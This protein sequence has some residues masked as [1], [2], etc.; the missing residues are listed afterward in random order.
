MLLSNYQKTEIVIGTIMFPYLYY[1]YL[2]VTKSPVII[3]DILWC[4]LTLFIILLFKNFYVNFN[5]LQAQTRNL[6]ITL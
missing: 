5:I 4:T 3:W 1:Y 2:R 6:N